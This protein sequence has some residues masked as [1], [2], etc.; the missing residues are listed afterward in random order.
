[1]FDLF[2]SRA[3]AVRYLLG[4]L[5]LLVALS[6]VVTLIPG[7]GTGGAQQDQVIAE[8]GK[9]KITA[10]EISQQMQAA[11]RNKTFPPEMANYYVSQLIDQAITSRSIVYAARQSGI[12]VT[13]ADMARTM[14][15]NFPQLFP[16]GQFIGTAAYEQMLASRNIT[17]P[18]FESQLRQ[19]MMMSRLTG[20]VNDSVIVTPDEVAKEYRRKN[21]KATLEY[22]AVSMNK[23][24][25]EVTVSPA[26]IAAFFN[27]NRPQFRTPAKRS[28]DILIADEARI[29]KR[30]ELSDADLEKVYNQN[31]DSFRVPERVHV[32]HILLKTTD[33]PKEDLPK[34]QARA[35]D[36]LKQVKGGAD[37]AELAKKNSDDPGSAAKGGDLGWIVRDQTV[38][39]FEAAAFSLKPKELSGVIKTEYGF[40][41]LQVLEKEEAHVKPFTE[42]K[43][44]IATE[45]KRSR[46]FDTLQKT[47]DQAHDE[48]AKHPE[49]AAEIASRLD[50][51]LVH[52]DKVAAG[53][54]IPEVGNN[55]ELSDAVL[56]L[57]KGGVTP[58]VQAPGNKLIVA[59]VTEVIPEHPAELA[60]VEGQ[61][62]E[63]LIAQKTSDLIIRRGQEV[64]DKVKAAGGDLKAVAKQMGLEVK[65]TPPFSQDGSAEGIGTA[66]ML[67]PAFEQPVGSVFGPVLMSDQR[68]ICKIESRTPADVSK[69]DCEP[70]RTHR[71]DQG[72]PQPGARRAVHGL[73]PQFADQGRQGKNSQGRDGSRHRQLPR[74][75]RTPDDPSRYRVPSHADDAGTAHSAVDDRP[76]R[77]ARL[78]AVVRHRLR[79]DGPVD[80]VL[81]AG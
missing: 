51:N 45:L 74:V 76:D 60:D 70:R 77:L 79:G 72:T 73:H 5:L 50:L 80:R 12:E 30:F 71:R 81:P 4:G 29:G 41:I 13:D 63:R 56:S 27:S 65:T 14:R 54:P 53:S 35:E 23:L 32:R 36:L 24:R 37:F 28:F 40:H 26:E 8:I 19:E 66:S 42:V 3:K 21:E 49:Q 15:L 55:P 62:R 47:A 52:A 2:R 59:V 31:K 38:K 20:L 58:V 39:A 33:K 43:D 78:C 9:E 68:F 69:L 17:I 57:Q 48:L 10:R 1:M 34:I 25:G 44:Q 7:Y 64:Y 22:L 75:N 16:Q 67:Q 61:I 6:M 18:E 46:V 11:M